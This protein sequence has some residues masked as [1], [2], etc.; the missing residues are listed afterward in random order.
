MNKCYYSGRWLYYGFFHPLLDRAGKWREKSSCVPISLLPSVQK[1]W[2]RVLARPFGN[3]DPLRRNKQP[4]PRGRGRGRVAGSS[5]H[6]FWLTQQVIW[7]SGHPGRGARDARA[8]FPAGAPRHPRP[9]PRHRV[10]ARTCP[11]AQPAGPAP[12][13]APPGRWG[14]GGD[15]LAPRRPALRPGPL[16]AQPNRGGG[17]RQAAPERP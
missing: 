16:A 6:F 3:G 8:A 11:T 14:R 12:P 17:D 1:V 2:P 5:S 13:P 10:R 7:G 15:S 4:R 9:R